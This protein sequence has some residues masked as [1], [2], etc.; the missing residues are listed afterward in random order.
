MSLIQK[1]NP[2]GIDKEI[3]ALQSYLYTELTVEEGFSDYQSYER[4]YKTNKNGNIIPEIFRNKNY[5]EALLNDKVNLNSFFVIDDNEVINDNVCTVGVSLIFQ[6]DLI[7]IYPSITNE[8]ADEEFRV[9]IKRLL[10][11]N[12]YSFKLTG[13]TTGINNV[14][15][16]FNF[17]IDFK[18][19]MQRFHVVRFDLELNYFIGNC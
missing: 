12:P 15:S 16:D 3:Q 19:D 6:V 4:V 14:Y 7:K 5:V 10:K 1:S 13:T 8:R 2:V 9:L 17:E 18:D 11:V